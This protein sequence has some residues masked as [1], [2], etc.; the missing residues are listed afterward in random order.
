VAVAKVTLADGSKAVQISWDKNLNPGVAYKGKFNGGTVSSETDKFSLSPDGKK[1]VY[2]YT[3][4][5]GLTDGEQ[6]KAEVTAYYLT[7]YY[8]AGDPAESPAYTH[9][10]P[11]IISSFNVSPVALY[12]D[13]SRNGSY[14][15][16]VYWYQR[17]AAPA[18]TYKLYRHKGTN[19]SSYVEWEEV[20]VPSP[21]IPNPDALG[22]IQVTL[23]DTNVP[24][25]RQAWTYK[26]VALVNN[27]VVDSRTATLDDDAWSTPPSIRTNASS[28][29]VAVSGEAGRKIKVEVERVTLGLYAGD[30]IE[31]YAVPYGFY[32]SSNAITSSD[33]Y[34]AQ[35]TPIGAISKTNLESDDAAK[36]TITSGSSVNAGGY[37][38]IAVLKNGDTKSQVSLLDSSSQPYSS[39]YVS[40]S[41]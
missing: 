21:G 23:N 38:V 14:N 41:N 4:L 28:N 16:S 9:S 34:L 36:R 7:K 30:T 29:P 31:F 5:S 10:D 39:W 17:P 22:F 6:Y 24:A 2:N 13:G 3:Y 33:E 25:Y 20:I 26:V 19:P 8:N 1:V 40:V 18:A 35:F 11:S 15:V 32:N 27:E 37:M 12:T